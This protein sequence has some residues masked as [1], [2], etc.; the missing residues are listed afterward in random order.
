MVP[1]EQEPR[2]PAARQGAGFLQRL[3]EPRF[4]RALALDGQPAVQPVLEVRI[5]PDGAP[6]QV[7][8]ARRVLAVVPDLGEV[9]EQRPASSSAA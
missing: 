5:E 7:G 2:A 8:R 1:R 3:Q 4:P 9:G 6:Q